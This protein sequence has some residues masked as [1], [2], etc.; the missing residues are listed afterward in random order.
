MQ[1]L[2]ELKIHVVEWNLI[3]PSLV[4]LPFG[5]PPVASSL[6]L[7][8][9]DWLVRLCLQCECNLEREKRDADEVKS[10]IL[11]NEEIPR[12]QEIPRVMPRPC[13]NPTPGSLGHPGAVLP[14]SPPSLRCVNIKLRLILDSSSTH[15]RLIEHNQAE[16]LQRQ[17]AQKVSC[18]C[19]FG[20]AR[21]EAMHHANQMSR[22][23]VSATVSY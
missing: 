5:L 17:N 3:L 4:S 23:S 16:P 10:P 6:L 1:L 20:L 18:R 2:I 19:M 7:F 13:A 9:E 22:I 21:Q 8:P 11:K 14:S 15:L 12:V